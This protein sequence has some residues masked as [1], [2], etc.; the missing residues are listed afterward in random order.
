MAALIVKLQSGGREGTDNNDPRPEVFFVWC[1]HFGDHPGCDQPS[2]S[3]HSARVRCRQVNIG[4]S[5]S[6]KELALV[7][8]SS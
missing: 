2:A 7:S 8:R 6:V 4:V 3:R 1:G 5:R